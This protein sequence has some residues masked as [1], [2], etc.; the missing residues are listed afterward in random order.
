MD[1]YSFS[2]ITNACEI[3]HKLTIFYIQNGQALKETCSLLLLLARDVTFSWGEIWQYALEALKNISCPY[4]LM[5]A[6]LRMYPK[7]IIRYRKMILLEIFILQYKKQKCFWNTFK[8]K[9]QQKL[10]S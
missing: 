1:Q 10:L 2:L 4:S 3:Q 5:N 9:G 6:L 8:Y 7:K